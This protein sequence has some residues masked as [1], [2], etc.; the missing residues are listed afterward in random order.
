MD[1][2]ALKRF[3]SQLHK[4]EQ[5]TISAYG[6]LEYS[7]PLTEEQIKDYALTPSPQNHLETVEKTEEQNYNQI[8]GILNNLPADEAAISIDGGSLYLAVQ[9]CDSGYDY[10][11]L[12]RSLKNWTEDS[13]TTRS[14]LWRRQFM[15]Y[16]QM[17]VGNRLNW[18]PRI[19]IP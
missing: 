11:F 8:D 14:F 9:T 15:N 5:G 2:T 19:M 18:K 17:K 16:F 4:Y 13:L 10:T 12:I 1:E 7:K 6:Y 3:T